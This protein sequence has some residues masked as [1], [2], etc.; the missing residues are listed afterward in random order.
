MAKSIGFIAADRS[1]KLPPSLRWPVSMMKLFE[2]SIADLPL[3]FAEKVLK[4]DERQLHLAALVQT[5]LATMADL[6]AE[7][8]LMHGTLMGWWWNRKV[9]VL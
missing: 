9:R 1:L 8:W 6:G 2:I 3:R 5:Y 7:T 4:E